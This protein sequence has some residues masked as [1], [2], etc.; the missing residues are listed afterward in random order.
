MTFYDA[1]APL[2]LETN[3]SGIGL[4]ARLSHVRDGMNCMHDKNTK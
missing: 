4:G 3:I 1:A 2:Y